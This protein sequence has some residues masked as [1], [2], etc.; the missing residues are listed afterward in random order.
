M[1]SIK[2]KLRKSYV[3]FSIT[4]VGIFSISLMTLSFLLGY[5]RGELFALLT[6]ITFIFY[7]FISLLFSLIN[8]FLLKKI[9]I[10]LTE[11]NTDNIKVNISKISSISKFFSLFSKIVFFISYNAL[12][13]TGKP[14]TNWYFFTTPLISTNEYNF[15]KEKMSRGIYHPQKSEIRIIDPAQFFIIHLLQNVKDYPPPLFVLPKPEKPSNSNFNSKKL[16]TNLG[17]STF[18]RSDD[19]YENR[20]YVPGDDPRKINW[21][22]FSHTGNLSVREGELLS[23]LKNKYTFIFNTTKNKS[24]SNLQIE[25]F[26]ILVNRSTAMALDFAKKKIP[27][28]LCTSLSVSLSQEFSH[29]E[30]DIRNRFA[31][32]QLDIYKS[33][34]KLEPEFLNIENKKDSIFFF[35]TLPGNIPEEQLKK[36]NKDKVHIYVGPL[37]YL[38]NK[39]DSSNEQYNNELHKTI[40]TLKEEGYNVSTI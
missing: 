33:K 34:E 18:H 23:P 8:M 10:S 16:T 3:S 31:F 24:F 6:G 15:T 36:F 4:P 26:D 14:T 5:F 39:K 17:K 2:K 20:I 30:E 12:T 13:D 19:L 32:P 21:K 25:L 22:I 40:M 38:A 35:F 1:K 28:S 9:N 27:I 11:T 7:V 37:A 29:K